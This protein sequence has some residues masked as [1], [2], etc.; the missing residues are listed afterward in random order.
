MLNV[1]LNTECL[2]PFATSVKT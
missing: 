1:N 2:P